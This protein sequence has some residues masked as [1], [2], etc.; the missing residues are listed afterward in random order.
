MA[1]GTWLAIEDA[2]DPARLTV[3]AQAL[4][5]NDTGET[6]LWDLFFPRQD[7]DSVDLANITTIDYRPTADR[8]E[9]NTR[10]RFVPAP[11]P[12]R[13]TVSIVPIEARDKID[14][15]AMQRLGESASGNAATIRDLIGV[16]VDARGLRL[17]QSCYRRLELD[18]ITAW[19]AGTIT[20]RNPEN[21]AQTFVA[22]FGFSG[23][24]YTTAGTAWDNGGVNAYNLLL[25]WIV[26]AED[27]VGSVKG[28]ML[29]LATLNAILADAPNLPN[30]VSMTRSALESRISDD[31]GK[32]FQFFVNENSVDVFDDGGLTYTRTKVWP[33]QKIAAIPSDGKIGFT[34]FAPVIRAME[35]SAQVPEAGIDINGV[36]VYHEESNGG[37]ELAIEAQLNALP[38][39]DEQRIYV[40]AV[41]V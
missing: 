8:R 5:P 38:V 37:R 21:A 39:P 1:I 30:S 35:M 9:W 25:A 26:A 19:T 36:T 23:S 28:A 6:L 20:Q 7:V 15:K 27:L 16:S 40:S 34:A 2:L 31:V 4:P 41:G 10:G 14:E 17:A 13:R 33:A 11:T 12:A 29:R 3:M 32:P 22:S 18:A 24:R